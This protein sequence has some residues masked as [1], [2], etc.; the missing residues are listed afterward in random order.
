VG[1]S[2][3]LL[4]ANGTTPIDADEASAL[5]PTHLRTQAELN[6]WEAQNIALAAEW[7]TFSARRSARLLSLPGLI[8]LHKRMFGATW[9][10]AGQLRTSDKGIGPYLPADIGRAL[11]D[12]VADTQTQVMA[13]DRSAASLDD[14]AVRFHHQ[15]VRIHPWPNGNGRHARFATDRVL[16]QWRRPAFSW[17]MSLGVEPDVRR[18]QYLTA[19]RAADQWDYAALRA[20]VRG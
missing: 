3:P 18:A 4:P 2:G 17:G 20:F 15:L 6:A 13:S 11:T 8:E 9:T 12:L 16:E 1:L 14:I 19:L 10:W 7:Y 5:L